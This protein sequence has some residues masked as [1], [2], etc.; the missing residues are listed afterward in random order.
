M[1]S[2]TTRSSMEAPSFFGRGRGAFSLSLRG[3]RGLGGL[4]FL[5]A[6]DDDDDDDNDGIR[7]CRV[8]FDGWDMV[9][10]KAGTPWEGAEAVDPGFLGSSV[11]YMLKV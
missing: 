5:A 6:D 10:D 2:E 4:G 1:A 9:F 11:E 3:W 8:P 7:F